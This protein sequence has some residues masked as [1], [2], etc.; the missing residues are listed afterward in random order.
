MSIDPLLTD[1]QRAMVE[2]IDAV[3][4]KVATD[5]YLLAC[6]RES[7][8]PSAV[9]DALGAAG[10][11]A[12]AVPEE[13]GG[14]DASAMDLSVVHE[15]IGRH[16]LTVAQ[17]YFSMWVLG[18]EAIARMG[19]DAQKK[20]W[21]PRVA[22]GKALIAFALTEPG[23]GSDAT[24]LTTRGVKG[25]T[26]Y[27]V[28]G[29]KTFITGAAVSDVIVTAVR[30]STG[31][32]KQEGISL[33]LID[34][35]A[36]GVTI[37]KIEKIG[38]KGIDLCE[39]YFDDVHVPFDQ[40]LGEADKGWQALGLGLAKERLFLAALSV[41]AHRDIYE[42]SLEHAT[43]R[44]AFGKRIGDYQMIAQKLVRMRLAIEKNRGLVKQAAAL[45]DAGHPDAAAISAM[46][47]LTATEDYITAAREGTQIFGGYGFALEYP[48]ARHYTDSKY[49]EVGG[50]T[51]E[52]MTIIV[53]RSLGLKP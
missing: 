8:Y 51:T 5:E 9:M 38:L 16:S 19:S 17:I 7:A 21:L 20:E 29:Q 52:I 18:G 34:P 41:G 15:A 32:K 3:C 13:Y 24:A 47:K 22:E 11:A 31:G 14:G 39:V 12:L 48:V 4:D 10:W 6:D 49:L 53:A 46:A 44:N 42:R 26:G 28:N 36:P 33:L 37:R 40:V 25:D 35:K 23:S 2:A 1:D 27:V 50:G 45:V 43:T 30:T